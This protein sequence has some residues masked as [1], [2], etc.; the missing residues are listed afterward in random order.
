[1]K[2]TNST[3]K[4]LSEYFNESKHFLCLGESNVFC[5]IIE[6]EKRVTYLTYRSHDFEEA[7][8]KL[9]GKHFDVITVSSSFLSELG[10][11]KAYQIFSLLHITLPCQKFLLI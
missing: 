8:K 11:P 1:M 4:L 10:N 6:N 3:S 2:M 5:E 9:N 7:F